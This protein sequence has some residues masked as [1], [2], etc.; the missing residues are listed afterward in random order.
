MSL[1]RRRIPAARPLARISHRPPAADTVPLPVAGWIA[2][3]KEDRL[4]GG[5]API[6]ERGRNLR[7]AAGRAKP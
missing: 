7:V 5:N 4:M 3:A 6:S 1:L 2:I